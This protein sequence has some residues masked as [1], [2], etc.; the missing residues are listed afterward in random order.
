MC[1]GLASAA[2]VCRGVR[3][4]HL[5]S[6]QEERLTKSGYIVRA[7]SSNSMLLQI[8][9]FC[10]ILQHVAANCSKLQ[11]VTAFCSNLQHVAS[12]SRIGLVREGL[13]SEK[14]KPSNTSRAEKGSIDQYN[15]SIIPYIIS[16]PIIHLRKPR[17]SALI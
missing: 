9:A 11:H 14:Q 15:Q 6:R 3:Y 8:A 17:N 5:L 10:S 1:R 13:G 7:I 4:A 2:S 12:W 16:K